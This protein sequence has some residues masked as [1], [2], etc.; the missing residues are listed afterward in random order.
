MIHLL[1]TLLVGTATAQDDGT[2]AAAE[3]RDRPDDFSDVV[4][5]W[6]DKFARWKDTRWFVATELVLPTGLQLLAKD[7][8]GESTYAFQVRAIVTCDQD[9]R[10]GK[11]KIEVSCKIVD[12]AIRAPTMR[13]D[14]T[15][16]DRAKV[17][18][19]LDEIDADMTGASVQMQVDERGSIT[20]IDLEGITYRNLRERQR[21]ESLRQISARLFYPFHMK[22][23]KT[24]VKEGNWP[25]FDSELMSMPSIDGVKGYS[26]IVHWMNF[27]KGYLLVQDIGTGVVS[28]TA[29]PDT[30]ADIDRS[31]SADTSSSGRST[32][33]GGLGGGGGAADGTVGPGALG[34]DAPQ[35]VNTGEDFAANRNLSYRLN[36]TGVSIYNIDNGIMEERVWSMVGTPTASNPTILKYWY[37]GRI[38]LLGAADNPDLGPTEQIS[39]PQRPVEGLPVWLPVDPELEK[40]LK[41]MIEASG[42]PR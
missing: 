1:T 22:L 39:Y 10:L 23:P 33:G 16:A 5:V 9:Y 27:Y 8:L 13:R 4:L 24:G 37:S 32:P 38:Q 34:G 12:F 19:I 28:V 40:D 30:I 15:A 26:T 3:E 25:E 7:N 21:F 29:P 17:Q 41:T 18:K 42:G 36:M 20:N 11:K 2:A 14:R 31:P 6:P 35:A